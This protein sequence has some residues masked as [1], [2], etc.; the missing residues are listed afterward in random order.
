MFASSA[1]RRDAM[2]GMLKPVRRRFEGA[3]GGDPAGNPAIA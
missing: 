2:A 1:G 3:G